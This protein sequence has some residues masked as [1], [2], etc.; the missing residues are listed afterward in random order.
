MT[1]L[2]LAGLLNCLCAR[3]WCPSV[4]CTAVSHAS[5]VQRWRCNTVLPTG[6]LALRLALAPPHSPTCMAAA[7]V[8]PAAAPQL[9]VCQP[10]GC[11]G[12]ASA[13]LYTA[14]SLQRSGWEAACLQSGF[15]RCTGK[16]QQR[17]LKKARRHNRQLDACSLPPYIH[18]LSCPRTPNF[19]CSVCWGD[20]LVVEATSL[21]RGVTQLNA[22]RNSSA[23]L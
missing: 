16:Q 4:A 6:T 7:P 11:C 15:E 5:V 2:M 17:Q 13:Q 14:T 8:C 18:E 20:W 23:V 21:R 3:L 10:G 9:P 1:L 19:N 22:I 12:G